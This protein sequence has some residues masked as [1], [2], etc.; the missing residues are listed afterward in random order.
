[1]AN[2]PGAKS[3][4]SNLVTWDGPNDPA[5]PQN[6]ST[7]RKWG[8]TGLASFITVNVTF[9]SSAPT[10]ITSDI[11]DA[12]KVPKEVANLVTSLFLLGYIFGPL[13][14]GPGSEL[15]G[16]KPIF[17]MTLAA[18]TVLYLGQTLAPNIQ[19]FLITR[20][21]AGF[22]AVGPLT[23]CGGLIADLWSAAGRGSAASLYSAC[24][25]FGPVMGPIVGGFIANSGL[26]WTWVFW[27][28][29]IYA[30]VCTLLTLLLPETFAPVLLI[31]KAKRL[32]SANPTLYKDI[33]AEHER[34]DWSLRHLLQRTIYRPIK[35]LG[36]EPIL[37][38][39]TLY[40]SLVYGVLYLLFEAVPIIFIKTRGFT[41]AQS[42]LAFIGVGIG[43][44]IGGLVNALCSRHYPALIEKWKGFPPPEQRLFGAMIGSPLLV[45]GT[46]WLGWTG[47]Y[48]SVPWYV[49][50]MSLVLIG[51]S[52][53]TIFISF[54]GYMIDTFST[55]SASA[56]AANI[57]IR[58]LAASAFPLFTN[59]L[60][61]KLGINWATTLIG[62]FS[63]ILAPIP[64]VFYRFGPRIRSN[65]EF[66][67]C[68]DLEIARELRE[69][70]SRSE[71]GGDN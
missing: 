35:M 26:H 65:S 58:S 50:A 9:A 39:V 69:Q 32:R 27:V 23:V 14:W 55:F 13:V 57:V 31:K 22:F 66:A 29:M 20:F 17:S 3:E 64:F 37:V 48:V 6:F 18:Y 19:V 24:V 52:I 1:M 41:K 42:G 54:N 53:C 40:I 63:I 30:G 10:T 51:F 62:I 4:V 47:Q 5:N 11:V 44:S 61:T 21:F 16:R 8:I 60:Y 49:P 68:K 59:Q 67:P 46:F 38:L 12:F 7:R 25:F 70:E 56:F 71:E 15:L 45:V 43:S 2:S 28:S 33:Y 34:H 36:S